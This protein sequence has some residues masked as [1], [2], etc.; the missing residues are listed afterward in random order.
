MKKFIQIMK[1]TLKNIQSEEKEIKRYNSNHRK[2]L[3]VDI[4]K[5]NN[6][7]FRGLEYNKWNYK[8]KY[9]EENYFDDNYNKNKSKNSEEIQIYNIN[10]FKSRNKNKDYN[11]LNHKSDDEFNLKLKNNYLKLKANEVDTNKAPNIK[12]TQL[13]DEDKILIATLDLNGNL[14]LYKNKK[15][16]VLFNLYK[17]EGIEKRYKDEEFFSVGFPYFITMNSKFI[18]ISTDHG[19]FVIT[20]Y[21]K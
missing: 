1:F 9:K 6:S 3:F 19:I 11:N 16:K 13:S 2:N 8:K 20:K 21:K 10:K 5:S 12:N 4:N 17:I 7:S 18:A 15:N 14:N